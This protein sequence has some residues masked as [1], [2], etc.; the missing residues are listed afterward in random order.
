V[1]SAGELAELVEGTTK[2]VLG[3]AEKLAGTIRFN[4]DLCTSELESEPKAEETLLGAV[5]KVPLEAAS[6][7]VARLHDAG[8]R[9]AQLR[10]LRA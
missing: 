2:L 1:N 5:V 7:V 4:T 3:L 9:R 6:F 10:K 8:P